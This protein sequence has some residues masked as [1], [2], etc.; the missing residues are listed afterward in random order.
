M[1]RY[2]RIAA[3][4]F[5]ALLAVALIGLWVRSYS[6]HDYIRYRMGAGH[7]GC[8]SFDGIVMLAH[9]RL[10]PISDHPWLAIRPSS[11]PSSLP[12]DSFTDIGLGFQYRFIRAATH[13]CL[14]HWFLALI[15]ASLAALFAFKR[16]WRFTTR[17]LLI[18][19]TIVAAA[20]GVGVCFVQDL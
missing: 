12:D 16:S 17:G 2:L 1:A 19:T 3:A 7:V 4:V 20:L 8:E 9:F 13:F 5:F 10:P 11:V 15:T 18:A 14:P 6:W